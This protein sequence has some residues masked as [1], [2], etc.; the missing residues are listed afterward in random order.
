MKLQKF[1]RYGGSKSQI[2]KNRKLLIMMAKGYGLDYVKTRSQKKSK[3]FLQKFKTNGSSI[4]R[5]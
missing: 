5:I 3:R 4:S 2:K 1:T